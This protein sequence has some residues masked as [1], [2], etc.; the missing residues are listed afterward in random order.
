MCPST[1][2][3]VIIMNTTIRQIA[4]QAGVSRGT[5]DR[6]LNDRPGVKPLVRDKIK[7]I[8]AQLN[9]APNVAA[10]ALA[11]SKKP[12]LF[13]IIMPPEDISF[14]EEIREGIQA[15]AEELK[16]LGI[17]LQ[18]LYV[19]N[20]EPEEGVAAIQELVAAGVAGIMFSVMDDA[21]IREN[22]NK[23]VDQ[24][25]PVITFNS[26]VE[27]T[28]RICFVG[29]DLYKSGR[30]AAGLMS[31]VVTTHP[32]ILIVIGSMRFQAHRTRVNGFKDWLTDSDANLEVMQVIE[33]YDRYDDTLMQ[34]N[35]ALSLNPD[36][37]GIYMATGHVGACMD[38]IKQNAG[39]HK[40]HVVCN[41]LMP[42]VEQGLREGIIDFTIVQSPY[43]QGYRT[44]RTLYEYI[45][46][47]KS[48]ESEYIFSDTHIKILESL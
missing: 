4:E 39:E 37:G 5:V 22:I 38:A 47:G 3:E 33:G 41:D 1:K 48:P 31:R 26:D 10:K 43:Q 18:Y 28:R 9:Y 8:A 13:G 42:E 7:K 46:K 15:A 35:H 12:A 16:D 19:N 17:R 40:I 23:A 36:I 27:N 11:Y 6:V 30:M 24:G 2:S 25:V 32:K 45:F 44:L 29:Q 34:I 21:L 14:F 20:K